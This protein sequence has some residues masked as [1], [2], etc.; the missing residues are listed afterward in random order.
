MID[1]FLKEF[2]TTRLYGHDSVSGNISDSKCRGSDNN[3]TRFFSKEYCTFTMG[4]INTCFAVRRDL[5]KHH[6][7][8]CVIIG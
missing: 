3:I 2:I 4:P 5:N 6:V 7:S 1:H 8:P